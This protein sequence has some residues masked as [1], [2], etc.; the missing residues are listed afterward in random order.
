MKAATSKVYAFAIVAMGAALHAYEQLAKSPDP[1]V[2]WFLWAMMPYAI[3]VLVI[4]LGKSGIPGAV[5]VSIAFALDVM[6]HNDVFLNPKGSTAALGL[7]FVPL[8]SSVVF[9]PVAMLIAWLVIRRRAQVES[10]AA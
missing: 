10:H 8:W 6:T 7:I 2:G 3:C 9:A 1:S 5:G 4:L